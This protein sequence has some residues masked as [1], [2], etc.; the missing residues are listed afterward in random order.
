MTDRAD[1]SEAPQ[2]EH[3]EV[4]TPTVVREGDEDEDRIDD[5][6]AREPFRHHRAPNGPLSRTIARLRKPAT[7]TQ[8]R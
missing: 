6:A 4:V 2:L 8:A 5:P 3:P 1:P 7:V